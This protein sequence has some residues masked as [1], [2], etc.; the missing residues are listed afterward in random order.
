[1]FRLRIIDMWIK[2]IPGNAFKLYK[3]MDFQLLLFGCEL[4]TLGRSNKKNES[5]RDVISELGCG[6]HNFGLETK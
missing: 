4:D 5:S 2:A 6:L 1:M 3:V